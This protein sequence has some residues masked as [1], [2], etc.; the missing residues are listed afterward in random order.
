MQHPPVYGLPEDR[1]KDSDKQSEEAEVSV[2]WN[3]KFVAH[4]KAIN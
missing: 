1:K 3:G 4:I 2:V